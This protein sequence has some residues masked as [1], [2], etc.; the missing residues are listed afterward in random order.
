MSSPPV[1]GRGPVDSTQTS[2]DATSTGMPPAQDAVQPRKRPLGSGQI[3]EL[4]NNDDPGPARTRAAGKKGPDPARPRAA[5][6]KRFEGWI[7][8]YMTGPAFEAMG[9]EELTAGQSA[10]RQ[11]ATP[12]NLTPQMKAEIRAALAKMKAVLKAMPDRKMT[13]R[14]VLKECGVSDSWGLE[15]PGLVRD[16]VK[17]D[18]LEVAVEAIRNGWM[19]PADAAFTF[20]IANRFN[21]LALAMAEVR[22]DDPGIPSE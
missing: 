11:A 20:R 2:H 5:G 17:H 16:P 10:T 15:Y 14:E 13:A 18:T 8:P 21:L 4:G 6:K 12:P 19:P 9:A 3:S 1:G 7:D 22:K